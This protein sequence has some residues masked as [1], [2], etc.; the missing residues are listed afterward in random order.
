MIGSISGKFYSLLT[1]DKGDVIIS[2]VIP[3]E[4]RSLAHNLAFHTKDVPLRIDIHKDIKN[5][6]ITANSY[7]HYLIQKIA[8]ATNLGF[9]NIKKQMVVEYGTPLEDENGDY[10]F[11]KVESSTDISSVYKY[12]NYIAC[13]YIDGVEYS[14]YLLYK[15]TH[16]MNKA[17]MARLIDGVVQEAKELGIKTLD[18]INLKSLVDTFEPKED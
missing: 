6:T 7:F 10:V 5:R 1:D 4:K 18:E 8:E 17:E 12:Y 16:M 14:T 2:F 9:E 13:D 11:V 3:K 15:Q